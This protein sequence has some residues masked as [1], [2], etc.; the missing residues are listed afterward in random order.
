MKNIFSLFYKIK[1]SAFK[2]YFSIILSS[3]VIQALAQSITVIS[4]NGGEKWEAN[5]TQLIK[6][7]SKYIDK[8]KIEY[9]LD[10]GLSWGNIIPSIDASLGEYSW[11]VVKAQTPYVLIKISDTSN[12]FTFDISNENFSVDIKEKREQFNKIT[13]ITGDTIKIMPLGDSITWGTNPDELNSPGYRRL[14]DSLLTNAGYNFDFVGSLIGGEPNDF[15]R[16]N[17]GHPGWYALRNTNTSQSMFHQLNNFLTNNPPEIV[18]IHIGTNDIASQLEPRTAAE[19]ADAV[20]DLLDIIYNYNPN[21]ITI[22]A[23]IIDRDDNYHQKTMDFNTELENKV[24]SLPSA[25]KEKIIIVD[26]YNELGVRWNNPGNINFSDNIHPSN[27]GYQKMADVWYNT[28]INVLPVPPIFADMKIFLQGPYNSGIMSTELNSKGYLQLYA[29]SQ[30]YNSSPWN[31]NGNES[32]SSNFYISNPSIVDWVLVE[33]RNK[34]NPCSIV[35]ARAGFIK[36]DGTIVDIDGSGSLSFNNISMDNYYITIKHRNHLAV[37]SASPVMLVNNT[38]TYDFTVDSNKFY[39]G[40]FAA[41]ELESGSPGIW[42]MFGSDGD[43]DGF[44]N[45]I[46]LNLVWR[47]QNGLDNYSKGDYNLDGFIN[48][49]DKNLFWRLNNGLDSKVPIN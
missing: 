41:K 32:V 17:E 29:Y 26:M 4:P 21:I 40:S 15:D 18:F 48:A 35:T 14:L 45:A 3:G 16:D 7:E 8:I 6:W 33:L 20:I 38:L 12:P 47:P 1:K 39:G 43:S 11:T 25:Q 28:L 31:Y 30:P 13:E 2:I 36:N 9:S 5:S 49:V 19:I 46:D 24:N 42:G 10:G 37:M 22:V 23:K 27:I 44:I 34:D